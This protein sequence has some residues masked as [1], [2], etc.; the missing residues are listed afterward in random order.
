MSFAGTGSNSLIS[1]LGSLLASSN[2]LKN[3]LAEYIISFVASIYLGVTNTGH[4]FCCPNNYYPARKNITDLKDLPFNL[5]V[6]LYKFITEKC[7]PAPNNPDNRFSAT[8][9]VAALGSIKGK[10]DINKHISTN[11]DDI[12]NAKPEE[13]G[14]LLKEEGIV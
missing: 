11:F 1:V 4:L 9:S 10:L 7:P 14:K 12:F 3:F 6:G 2:S 13:I 5:M 8:T